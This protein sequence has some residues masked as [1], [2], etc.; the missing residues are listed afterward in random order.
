MDYENGE[1]FSRKQDSPVSSPPI[2]LSSISSSNKKS[3]RTPKCDFHRAVFPPVLCGEWRRC[4]FI[5]QQ[6]IFSQHHTALLSH[7]R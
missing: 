3:K 4:E 7:L 5:L 2:V 6:N 1:Y